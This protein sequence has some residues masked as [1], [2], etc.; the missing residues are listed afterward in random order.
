MP[1]HRRGTSLLVCPPANLFKVQYTKQ[2]A[3]GL[4]RAWLEGAEGESVGREEGENKTK[5]KITTEL[6][7]K[8]AF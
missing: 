2:N 7:I 8:F 3:A 4:E 5:Q 1:H 6:K